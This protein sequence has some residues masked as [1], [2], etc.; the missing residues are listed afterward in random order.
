M[1]STPLKEARRIGPAAAGAFALALAA[2]L[3]AMLAL[4]AERARAGDMW[5]WPVRGE[6]ITHYQNDNGKPY[7]GGMHRGI[8]IAADEGTGVVAAR[9]G[10]VRYAGPLGSSGI[11]VSLAD[12]EGLIESYLHLSQVSV[13]RG[14][15]ISAG[16]RIGSVGTTGRRSA[17]RP[18]LH[19]GVRSQERED[20]YYDPLQFLPMPAQG[21]G[22]TP[23]KEGEAVQP[24]VVPE[25]VAATSRVVSPALNRQPGVAHS[26]SP[27]YRPMPL[28][29]AAP[30]SGAVRHGHPSEAPTGLGT[31]QAEGAPR[32]G[33]SAAKRG[34][35]DGLGG[36]IEAGAGWGASMP[37]P[38]LSGAALPAPGRNGPDWRPSAHD[39]SAMQDVAMRAAIALAVLVFAYFALGGWLHGWASMLSRS[40]RRLRSAVTIQH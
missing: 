39:G 28:P 31:L 4:G 24:K 16:E 3:A 7:A 33:R 15:A 20:F 5:L 21:N 35:A 6:V 40:S 8:D 27:A 22:P 18:H 23:V 1:R 32:V 36:R 11:T 34:T 38:A 29:V 26:P 10:V 14:Q 30:G 13:K 12:G 19:F 37:A 17:E 2:T 25:P 9:G